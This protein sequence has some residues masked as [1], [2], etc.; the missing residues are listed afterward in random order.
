[1]GVPQLTAVL[2]SAQVSHRRG[3]PVIADGG[4]RF[5]ADA[6]KAIGAGASTVML[7]NLLAGAEES[8]GMVV[9][10]DGQRM[11]VARGILASTEAAKDRAMRGDP[12]RGWATARD[13]LQRCPDHPGDV[14]EGAVC[15]PD[16]GRGP[17]GRP[18]RSRLVL[19][20][21]VRSRGPSPSRCLNR[22]AT[23]CALTPRTVRLRTP[24]ARRRIRAP[25]PRG[26][27]PGTGIGVPAN[28][29][30]APS[31]PPAN[32]SVALWNVTPHGSR[33][34]PMLSVV[35]VVPP[36]L[37]W[38]IAPPTPTAHAGELLTT[39]KPLKP[40]EVFSGLTWRWPV[41]HEPE[42]W[43]AATAPVSPAKAIIASRTDS[44]MAG[45][46][47]SPHVR[48]PLLL[49]IILARTRSRWRNK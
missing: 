47:G 31:T 4:V 29:R 35:H 41:C 2:E 49:R 1:M 45:Q 6:A 38:V 3:V 13:K 9:V 34:V 24:Q 22:A 40:A 7:G 19:A 37:V 11:K 42:A 26:V 36:L 28:W 10:R 43:A 32:P 23:S 21:R 14:G 8:P 30:S 27:A 15:P 5:A 25:S 33:V 46:F 17:R 39:A 44:A 18:P 20:A 48:L 16:G 12:A